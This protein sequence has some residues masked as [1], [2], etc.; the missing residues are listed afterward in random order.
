[1]EEGLSGVMDIFR[2]G[3]VHLVGVQVLKMLFI[4]PAS[5]FPNDIDLWIP[6]D[7]DSLG[8]RVIL[9]HILTPRVS[10]MLVGV[11]VPVSVIID[12]HGVEVLETFSVVS[13]EWVAVVHSAG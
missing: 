11:R 7:R 13:S 8:S 6:S 3:I 2:V 10:I 9:T 5:N 1:M 4:Q 12:S